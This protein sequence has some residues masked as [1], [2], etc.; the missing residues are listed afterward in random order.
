[1]DLSDWVGVG[2]DGRYKPK[3]VVFPFLINTI[4]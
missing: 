2:V 1:M 4:I 3:H